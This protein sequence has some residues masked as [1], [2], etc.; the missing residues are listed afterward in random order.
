[1][2]GDVWACVASGEPK[3]KTMLGVDAA[4]CVPKLDAC[5]VVD[6]IIAVLEVVTRGSRVDRRILNWLASCAFRP[7]CGRPRSRQSSIIV[8]FRAVSKSMARSLSD[9]TTSRRQLAGKGENGN[10]TVTPRPVLGLAALRYGST[11][12]VC[13]CA[14]TPSHTLTRINH[15][16]S[17]K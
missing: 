17:H 16:N 14:D 5:A 1:M 2:S 3:M 6:G 8:A 15:V 9:A 13:A 10:E 7:L 11:C 12:V 4:G